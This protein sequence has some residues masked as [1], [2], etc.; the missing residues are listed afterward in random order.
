MSKY[1]LVLLGPA[2]SGKSTQARL[3]VERLQVEHIDMGAALRKVSSEDTVFGRALYETINVRK[4]LVSDITVGNVLD[5]EMEKIP[6]DKGVVVDGA[7]RRVSQIDEVEHVFMHYLRTIDKVIF[8]YLPEEVSVDRIASRF[9]CVKCDKAY[10]I[11]AN[12]LAKHTL[13]CSVC[14][15]GLE[16]RVDDTPE[17]VHKRLAVFAEETMP[18][19]EHYRAKGKLLQ[20]DGTKS[21]DEIFKD[22]MIEV[23]L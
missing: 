16:Q 10:I 1:N 14:G 23:A 12:E 13:K 4:E 11:H 15:G 9:A 20:V 22:I 18:V 3:I 19:I 8:I 2:G 17:G 6:S 7:P 5:H 21:A